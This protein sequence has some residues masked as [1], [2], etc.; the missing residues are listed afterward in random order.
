MCI[1]FVRGGELLR[2]Q[3]IRVNSPRGRTVN[4]IFMHFK[5][6]NQAKYI[7]SDGQGHYICSIL[8]VL[9]FV[10]TTM[11]NNAD[12]PSLFV[13]YICC[14]TEHMYLRL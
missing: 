11:I 10:H 8:P 6:K 2:F 14:N 9:V 13:I 7:D 3:Y 4:D 12:F 1:A 5:Q